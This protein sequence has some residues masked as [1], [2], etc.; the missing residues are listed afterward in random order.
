MG[1]VGYRRCMRLFRVFPALAAVCFCA[2]TL[3]ASSQTRVLREISFTGAPAYSQA[4]LLAFTGLKPGGS[5]SQQQVDDAA[6]RLND[7]GLFEEV[8]FSGN[9]RGIVYSLKPAPAT[10]MLPARFGNFV[11][12]QD[13]EIE[14]TLK[15]HVALYRGDA[16]PTA[17]NL[18]ESV[19]KALT[20]M[21]VDKGLAGATVASRLSSSRPGGPLDHIKFVID[22]PAVVIHSLSLVDASPGMQPKLARVIQDVAGQQWDEGASYGN[23]ESRVGDVYHNQ[24]YLDVAVSKQEHSSPVVTAKDVEL[25]V[26]ST[27]SEG[28]QYHVTQIAWPGSEVLSTADFNSKAKLK[29]GDPDSPMA[30]RESLNTI[31]SAYGTKGYLDAKVLA[32]PVI[33]R[34]A[35]QVAYSISVVPG[36]QYHFKSVR[37]PSVS[38]EQAKEFDAAW[39]M[40]PGDVYDDSYLGRFFVQST[41]LA[42]QGYKMNAVFKRDPVALTVELSV[43][44]SKAGVTDQ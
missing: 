15:A 12:W 9:D 1:F 22:S 6:Q 33:D 35:H 16:V 19:S 21:L 7:T 40:L 43:T 32:P 24:G 39:K 13:D 29:P 34:T 26:T 14:R 28:A 23:I 31:T 42:K 37:W 27:L 17:G 2:S 38:A 41:S 44:F 3:S 20:A 18:R 25:D 8:N 5:V 11:W 10:A 4:E 30:L 36:P